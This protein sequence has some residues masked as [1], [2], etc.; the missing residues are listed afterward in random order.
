M[1]SSCENDIYEPDEEDIQEDS[2]S[3]KFHDF[4]Q[5][6]PGC[7]KTI[8]EE[9][10]SCPYCGDIIFRHLKDGMFAPRKGLLTT[11]VALLIALIVIL[12]VLGLLLHM[13]F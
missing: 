2:E 4:V 6:C 5:V 8:T 11:I 12:S 1:N 9:M 10:D 13:I 3:L 7:K